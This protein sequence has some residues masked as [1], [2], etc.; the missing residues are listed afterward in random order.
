MRVWGI[1]KKLAS[2]MAMISKAD[3]NWSGDLLG[4]GGSVSASSSGIFSDQAITWRARTEASEG[5]T[6][7]EELLASAHAAC[8]SMALSHYE[9]VPPNVQQQ[10]IANA[11]K[12]KDVTGDFLEQGFGSPQMETLLPL[13]YDGGVNRGRIGLVPQQDALFDRLDDGH[14]HADEAAE[15]LRSAAGQVERHRQGVEAGT[16]VDETGCAKRAPIRLEGV[17]FRTNSAELTDES[18]AVFSKSD[19]RRE[20]LTRCHPSPFG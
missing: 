3:A 17:N 16:E 20:G 9:P 2:M 15:Q 7:P 13:V 4:G 1:T 10:I 19:K 5:K 8:Y 14:A 11:A 6:S 12:A 18:L